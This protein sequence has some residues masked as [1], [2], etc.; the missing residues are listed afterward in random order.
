MLGTSACNKAKTPGTTAPS[1][2]PDESLG[3]GSQEQAQVEQLIADGKFADAVA[4]AD[5]LLAKHPKDPGLY[6]AKGA[7]LSR[8]DKIEE[9]QAALKQAIAVDADFVPAYVALAREVGFGSNDLN[10]ARD[11]AKKAVGLDPK[12]AEA[13]LVLAMILHD[14]GDQAKAI[15]TLE[16]L[17]AKGVKDAAALVELSRLYAAKGEF[18]KARTSLAQAIKKLPG[19]QSVPARL[20]LGRIEVQAGQDAAAT[21]A[22]EAAIAAQPGNWDISL[23]VVR[24]YLSAN[25]PKAALPYAQRVVDAMPKQAPALVAMARVQLGLGVI[26][27]PSGAMTWI[28][29][30]SELAPSSLA[31]QYAHAQVLAG[32]G[33]CDDAKAVAAKLRGQ[34]RAGRAKALADA[35]ARCG[36]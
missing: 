27:G 17:L 14:L 10:Q 9:A 12:H 35:L 31:V 4:L 22:F 26:D 16:A 20:L 30:A 21:K 32:A 1:Q 3:Q 24:G 6:Y 5:A 7:A 18:D 33:R 34:L 2:E 25:K 23:A 15:S 19:E 13:S 11:Y 28:E 8:L 36:A 29:K